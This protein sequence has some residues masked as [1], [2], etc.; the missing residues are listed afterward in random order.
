MTL[1]AN[2]AERLLCTELVAELVAAVVVDVH[3]DCSLF[4]PSLERCDASCDGLASLGVRRQVKCSPVA[5]C[6]PEVPPDEVGL[7][8]PS[9]NASQVKPLFDTLDVHYQ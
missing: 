6:A 1:C 4:D 8:R 2:C 3:D 7:V 5:R 9:E